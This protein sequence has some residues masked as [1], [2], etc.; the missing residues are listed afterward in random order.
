[1]PRWQN[2][3]RF[4]PQDLEKGFIKFLVK[5]KG[6]AHSTAITYAS[7]LRQILRMIEEIEGPS[8]NAPEYDPTSKPKTWERIKENYDRSD[9]IW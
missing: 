7:K 5:E 4:F 9:S 2:A 1:M 6:K 8:I 3:E